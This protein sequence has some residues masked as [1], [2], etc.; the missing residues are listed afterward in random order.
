[1]K[2]AEI[3]QMPTVLKPE[4]MVA[5]GCHESVLRSYNIVVKIKELLTADCPPAILLEIIEDL[6]S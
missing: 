5:G 4:E 6:Q 2:L 3:R 1:M